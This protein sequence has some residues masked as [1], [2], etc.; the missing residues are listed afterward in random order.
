MPRR[1]PLSDRHVSVLQWIA[2]GCPERECLM[3]ATSSRRGPDGYDCSRLAMMAYRAA[4]IAIPRAAAAQ[5]DWGTQ[6]PASQVQPGDPVFFSGADGTPAAPGH[7]GIVLNPAAH[8]MVN[9]YTS[10]SPW[11]MTPTGSPTPRAACRGWWA[12]LATVGS[13]QRCPFLER[14]D[15]TKPAG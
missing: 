10:A 5:W 3:R 14:R 2:D 6:I 9:T 11:S 13:Q 8:T 7:V 4:G 1:Q 12:S 15:R